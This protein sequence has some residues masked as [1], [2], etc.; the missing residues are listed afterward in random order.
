M[1]VRKLF[2][3]MELTC[4]YKQVKVLLRLTFEVTLKLETFKTKGG[5]LHEISTRKLATFL[6]RKNVCSQIY[7]IPYKGKLNI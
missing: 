1:Y 6:P 7:F 2:T 5:V 4:N 3:C